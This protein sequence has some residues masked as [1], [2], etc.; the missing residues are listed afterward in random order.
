MKGELRIL[1]A[2]GDTKIIWD[3]D[4]DDE[5]ENAEQTFDDLIGKGFAAFK[6]RG[7]GDKGEQV[8]KFD[9]S[10]G[11]LILVPQMAGG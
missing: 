8:K 6:V 4:N 9:A 2:K 10:A 1:G 11:K 7:K 3:S 5:V